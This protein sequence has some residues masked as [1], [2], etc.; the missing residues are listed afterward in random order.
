M[1]VPARIFYI[2]IL[3]AALGFVVTRLSAPYIIEALRRRGLTRRDAHKPGNPEVVHSGGIIIVLAF[4]VA[5]AVTL[6]LI[7]DFYL[8]LK[9]AAVYSAAIICFLVGIY[10][11]V[12]IL[13]G[14]A[15]TL[16]T[17]LAV[18][19]IIVAYLLYPK[20][21]GLGHPV[22]PFIGK[23][24]V[25]IIY[26]AILPLAVA[27]PANLVNMLDIFNGVTPGMTLI[28][29]LALI[30][31]AFILNSPLTWIIAAV[32]AS[33]LAA[34]Y[35]FNAYPAR[36]FN[37]DSG[38]LFIGGLLGALAV[39][40]HIEFVVLTLLIPHLINGVL[41]LISFGG[42]KE[43]RR[44]KERP[45]TVKNH[46]LEASR[47][48]R[49]PW[50]LTRLILLIGGP[51]REDEVSRFYIALETVPALLAVITAVFMR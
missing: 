12:K 40:G 15:K 33:I 34:Y 6:I 37:G 31:S 48:P 42:F 45:I 13:S 49:A 3:A 20:V 21:I 26:W 17:V 44:V 29:S 23:I 51:A 36:V 7:R 2:G 10:D 39:V 1:F 46:V 38:S 41:V 9:I 32:L 18:A 50:T 28:A 30:A 35:P 27:G 24:R 16:L 14:K 4:T 19:P 47:D 43:H 5:M 11:D 25:T 22:V 8:G